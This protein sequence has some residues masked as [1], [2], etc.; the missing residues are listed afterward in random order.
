MSL[1]YFALVF[2][3]LLPGLAPAQHILRVGPTQPYTT[4]Q[5]A[6]AAATDHDAIL[7]ENG[8]YL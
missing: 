8:T 7:I 1:I 5:A 6:I 3:M 4:I 2:L